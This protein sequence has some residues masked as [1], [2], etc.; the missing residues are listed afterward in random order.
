MATKQGEHLPSYIVGLDLGNSATNACVATVTG[1]KKIGRRWTSSILSSRVVRPIQRESELFPPQEKEAQ[2]RLLGSEG[3]GDWWH[4]GDRSRYTDLAYAYQ[5]DKA[6]WMLPFLL[7]SLPPMNGEGVVVSASYH[8]P[9]A[10]HSASGLS[11]EQVILSQLRVGQVIEYARRSYDAATRQYKETRHSVVIE[12]AYVRA[13]GLGAISRLIETSEENL[14]GIA[15]EEAR[16]RYSRTVDRIRSGDPV[17]LVDAGGDTLNIAALSA[18]GTMYSDVHSIAGGG[19]SWIA[20]HLSENNLLKQQY[21]RA[22]PT[23]KRP[24]FEQIM[25]AL[26]TQGHFLGSIPLSD[27]MFGDFSSGRGAV[28]DWGQFVLGNL[29]QLHGRSA[30]Q[31]ACVICVGGTFLQLEEGALSQDWRTA[32][33]RRFGDMPVFIMPDPAFANVSGMVDEQILNL[34]VAG[35]V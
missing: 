34:E 13:E 19:S 29:S 8:S 30:S 16:K 1:Q 26:E 18:N 24:S 12:R 31:F 10:I 25:L 4:I 28:I 17:I 14:K 32:L 22:Y 21:G 2:V 7:A 6:E 3:S 23:A 27:Y 9:D 20:R 35:N 5:V 15:D 33:S 11:Y